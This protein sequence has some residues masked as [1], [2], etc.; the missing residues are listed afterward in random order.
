MHRLLFAGCSFTHNGD[1]W[2]HQG[3]EQLATLTEQ[4][5]D[6]PTMWT[7]Q[8]INRQNILFNEKYKTPFTLMS[9]SPFFRKAKKL[10]KE[11][12]EINILGKSANSNTDTARSV[13]HF[14][15]NY[16]HDI[17]MLVF[18]ISGFARREL[19]CSNPEVLNGDFLWNDYKFHVNTYDDANFVKHWGAI[20]YN[21]VLLED[22]APD[23]F[24]KASAYFYSVVNEPEEYHIRAIEQLQNLTNFCK[25]NNI[26]LAYFHGWQNY[27]APMSLVD[28]NVDHTGLTVGTEYFNKKYDKYV[29]PYLL[30]A[31][32][33]IQYADDNMERKF[34]F[35]LHRTE[36]GDIEHGSHPS[37]MS[38]QLFWNDI[39]YP[40]VVQNA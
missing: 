29:R 19:F 22:P 15:E 10:P 30:E 33:L 2:A 31:D 21:K 26:K 25:V 27:P 7:N 1:S 24:R 16:E 9:Y 32:N 20:D 28:H 3:Q 4:H 37:P 11:D 35:D 6:D 8:I 14:V 12:Y 23:Y 5:G 39:V 34:V 17:D 13:M 38:H 40:F 18:Q 36:S